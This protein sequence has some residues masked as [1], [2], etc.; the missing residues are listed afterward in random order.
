MNASTILPAA[1][2]AVATAASAATPLTQ[3]GVLVGATTEVGSSDKEGIVSWK[4]ADS[5]K[6][7]LSREFGLIQTTSY[8]S[9]DTWKGSGID[10]VSFDMTNP[11]KVIDFAKSQGKKVVVHLMAGSP[12]YFPTWLNEGKWTP[13]QLEGL[14]ERW[15]KYAATT[16]NNASKIDYWNV[17][18]EAFM[19]DGNYWDSSSVANTCPWQAMGWEDDKSGLTGSSKVYARHPVYIRKAFELARKY[20]PNA[21]LELRDYGIELWQPTTRKTRVFYQLIKHLQNSGVPIDAVGMQ[22][23][24]RTDVTYDWSKLKA[25]VQEYRKMGL[26]VYVTEVDYG[27]ADPIAA[28]TSAHRNANFDSTQSRQYKAMVTAAVA[29]GT[30]WICLWGVADNTNA[31][32]RMGQSALLFDENYR[33]KPVVE[34]FR[35]GIR[36]GLASTSVQPRAGADVAHYRV[37]DGVL[38]TDLSTVDHVDLRTATGSIATRVLLRAGRGVL[39]TLPAGVYSVWPAGA[40]TSP[41][42]VTLW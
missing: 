29:G 14:L 3:N 21:K 22:G 41:G 35:Q 17:V 13:A 9:W 2:L 34:A 20:A 30:N 40:T 28:A 23:H 38:R 19:W 4:R 16:N 26:E 7:V 5:V 33:P 18:N 39:P 1:L 42:F 24:F 12:T 6:S 31:Y 32:W 36:E 27:D 8:P 37:L 10:G 15:I 25:F 11:N